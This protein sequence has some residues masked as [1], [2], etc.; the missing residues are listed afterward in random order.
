ML[1]AETAA[2]AY[3]NPQWMA[4]RERITSAAHIRI[5][6]NML[7]TGWLRYTE[8]Q[9]GVTEK[10]RKRERWLPFYMPKYEFE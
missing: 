7:M 8:L 1:C 2:A 10:H 3:A 6:L 5:S 9:S 4:S